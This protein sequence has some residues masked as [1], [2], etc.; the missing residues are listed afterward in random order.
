MPE[1]ECVDDANSPIDLFP[2][3]DA[4]LSATFPQEMQLSVGYYGSNFGNVKRKVF[5]SYHHAG[6]QAYYNAFSQRFHDNYDVISD[7]SLERRV[8]S[9]DAEYVMRNI[10]ENYITGS[11]CT[12]VLVGN[13]TWGRR[14]VDWEIK[15]TLDRQHSLIGVQLPSLRPLPNGLYSV[16]GR[17]HDNIQSGYAL[18]VTWADIT[19][20]PQRCAGLIEAA[21]SRNR[22]FI[23]NGRDR[24]V[25]NLA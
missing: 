4:F 6:D 1:P 23:M 12:I 3:L 20:S 18:W 2:M 14:Y 9:D 5:V 8:N 15:A 25:R 7:N 17:L 10:R 21:A 22:V 13:Q 11:S 24:L 16:P 19:S